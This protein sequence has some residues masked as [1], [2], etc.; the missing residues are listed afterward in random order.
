MNFYRAFIGT[1]NATDGTFI[2]TIVFDSSDSNY[3]VGYASNS[4]EMDSKG[5]IYAGIYFLKSAVSIVKVK[6]GSMNT[7]T[8]IVAPPD[9]MYA[10]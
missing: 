9:L 7:R 2:D 5:F 6:P 8:G 3:N 1:V 4:I 10:T